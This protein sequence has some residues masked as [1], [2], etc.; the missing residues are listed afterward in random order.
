MSTTDTI[1]FKRRGS[2][3][4]PGQFKSVGSI[5]ETPK[6]MANR[7]GIPPP[8]NTS[9]SF[10]TISAYSQELS[11]IKSLIHSN[12]AFCQELLSRNLPGESILGLT[13]THYCHRDCLAI[14]IQGPVCQLCGQDTACIDEA[15]K[16]D[17]L[18]ELVLEQPFIA[19]LNI[20]INASSSLTSCARSPI[21]PLNQ[22]IPEV[23]DSIQ[24]VE[25]QEVSIKL[26]IFNPNVTF[27]SDKDQLNL[28]RKNIYDLN[29]IINVKA[30]PIFQI[31]YEKD[32]LD[33]TPI[34]QMLQNS[35]DNWLDYFSSKDSL[36]DLVMFDFLSISTNGAEWVLIGCFFFE[37]IL[38]LIEDTKVVGQVLVHTD[39]A[40][41]NKV[42][43]CLILNL[44]NEA[45]PE[46]QIKH[47]N[48]LI[49]TK[50]ESIFDKVAKLL[51][52]SDLNKFQFSTNGWPYLIDNGIEIPAEME[53]FS[54]YIT[55]KEQLPEDFLIQALP[56]P[57]A[58]PINLIVSVPPINATDLSHDEYKLNII[59]L[60]RS[61]RSSL[62]SF[63]KL[64]LIFVGIDCNRNPSRSGS[65]MACVEAN[66]D[67]WE[68][69]FEDLR[70]SPNKRSSTSVLSDDIQ[71]LQISIEKCMDLYPFIP[72]NPKIV[73]KL[74]ILNCN[75]LGLPVDL[76]ET[77]I[78]LA[79]LINSLLD[80]LSITLVRIG[81]NC[82]EGIRHIHNLIGNPNIVEKKR[83]LVGNQIVEKKSSSSSL[84]RYSQ[85]NPTELKF[86]FGSNLIHFN[87]FEE[88]YLELNGLVSEFQSIAVPEVII[89]L[90]SDI[91]SKSLV[92]FSE[93]EVNGELIK[94]NNLDNYKIVVKDISPHT[95]R[96]IMIR[97]I[98]DLNNMD[99]NNLFESLDT[100]NELPVLN[101]GV[102][103]FGE[104]LNDMTVSLKLSE[105]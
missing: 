77:N 37:N 13:C 65:F 34:T 72:K 91:R 38:I 85:A 3:N 71:E 73:N 1:S 102:T 68:K 89:D 50:W 22:I 100:P 55:N 82:T 61:I 90:N 33:K 32:S 20:P 29:Y 23:R 16:L 84:N 60:L 63:D 43:N 69:L 57:Q 15:S 105:V 24:N 81:D 56:Q 75:N 83:I 86:C 54:R 95:E 103:W 80:V 88:F 48:L 41:V 94:L 18:K 8:I 14:L 26:E 5:F 76:E 74:L 46:L 6:R 39:I 79:K 52:F 25:V 64:G 93:L 45:I 31:S 9:E 19:Q 58:L 40:S 66:W 70:I 92:N 11:S 62:R 101:Y 21:T 30:P 96:N 7:V 36:G 78:D 98:V 97:I 10:A 51:E 35:I 42:R 59:T 49:I 99:L 2:N 17:L 28:T 27:L 67:G 12:C 104:Q 87:S 53:K 44:R 47:E 4:F